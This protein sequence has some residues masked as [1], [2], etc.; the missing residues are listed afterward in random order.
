MR[1]LVCLITVA[2]L[3]ANCGG[4]PEKTRRD[5]IG[6]IDAQTAK[7]IEN[8]SNKNFADLNDQEKETAIS[9]LK[10]FK[11]KALAQIACEIAGPAV[12]L[13]TGRNCDSIVRECFADADKLPDSLNDEQAGKAFDALS[14]TS[15]STTQYFG[16]LKD[17]EEL[18]NDVN[19]ALWCG[20]TKSDLEDAGQKLAEK[21]QPAKLA[22]IQKQAETIGKA[23]ENALM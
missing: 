1:K 6:D 5:I 21:Y 18:L 17:A 22:D 19:Q 2:L 4:R 9:A 16:F 10:L 13:T 12:S 8:L 15:L 3:I 23:F 20:M 11:P 7:N 14:S